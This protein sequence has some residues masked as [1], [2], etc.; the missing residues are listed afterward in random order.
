MARSPSRREDRR[1]RDHYPD[2][3]HG[4]DRWDDRDRHRRDRSRNRYDSHR[5][6]RSRRHW[7]R[8]RERD[9]DR[10]WVRE[11]DGRD[12]DGDRE[13]KRPREA[14]PVRDR[15][16]HRSRDDHR[17]KRVREDSPR[18]RQRNDSRRLAN[19]EEQER[20]AEEE[21][22]A[23]LARVAAWKKQMEEKKAKSGTSPALPLT[24]GNDSPAPSS[25]KEPQSPAPVLAKFD[26]KA[27]AKRAPSAA[28]KNRTL[29][30][31]VFI[32]TQNRS[33]KA[34]TVGIEAN[35][36]KLAPI[37]SVTESKASFG[38]GK[39]S[40]PKQAAVPVTKATAKLEED[41]VVRRKLEKLPALP[42]VNT[43]AVDSE[44]NEDEEIVGE[45]LRTDEEEAEAA[46]ES[47]LRRAQEAQQDEPNVQ[48][49]DA[50]EALDEDD[51]LD[52]FMNSLAVP[53]DG[54][55][56]STGKA[57]QVYNSDDE[58]NMDAVGTNTDEIMALTTKKK[59]KEIPV[60]DHSKIDYEPFHKAFYTEPAELAEMSQEDLDIL[61]SDLDNITLRGKNA[62]KPILKWSQGGF[63]AQLL[64]VLRDNK[65]EKPTPIQSQTLPAIMS[66]RDVMGIAKTGSGKTVAYLLPMFRHIKDQRPLEKLDGPIGLILAPTRELATQIHRECKPYLKALN[67][68]AV[69]AYGGAPIKDQIAELKRGA[70]IVVCTPGRMI[71]LLAAN[72]GRVTNLKR[73]TYAVLDEADRMFDMGFEPQITRILNNV[74]PDRQLVLFSA[75]FPDKMEWLVKRVLKNP[76]AVTVGG[77][78]TVPA[79]ITQIIELCEDKDKLTRV[80]KY[81]GDLHGVDEDA[82]SLI[83]VER[84][85][86]ADKMFVNLSAKGYPSVPIHGGREQIDRDQAISDFKAGIFP[87]MVATSV[88]ARGLDVKQLKLVINY[89]SPNHYEDYVHRVG[90]TG[91]AGN[92]GTAVTFVTPDQDRFADFL[93]NAFT[94]SKQQ[95]PEELQK[96]KESYEERK[97]SGGYKK[98]SS[99]F[100]GKGIEKLDAARELERA[101]ERKQYRNGD[102]PDEEDETEDINQSKVDELVARATGKHVPEESASTGGILPTDLA[103]HLSNAMKV[104]KVSLPGKGS[105]PRDA[106]A[107]VSA[108]AANIN[109][110]LG[111]RGTTRQGAPIDNRGPDAGAYHATLEINDFPQKAR[112]A[113]TNR[114][115]VAK[116]LESTGTSITTKGNYY[117]PGKE[118]QPGEQPKLY[119]LVE[120]DTEV[121]VTSAMSELTRLLRE[122][123]LAALEGGALSQQG[124]LGR[125][126][127]I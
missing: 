1:P 61:L 95:V 48:M 14:S 64:D 21:R 32:P 26:P 59:K 92:T 77:K 60:V 10:D 55:V 50:P 12:R 45:E 40:G 15:H 25:A 110:R 16:G 118:P 28:D 124:T 127:V 54:V 46:R 122:G 49:T 82:R 30:G 65:F 111:S 17:D 38:L 94:T 93:I 101:R 106:L 33:A 2:R 78:S 88:A 126:S 3:S 42:E 80:L 39:I 96:L 35:A 99:G 37:G 116:I 85:E 58:D 75:T 66:G 7:D 23:K 120:G 27:I 34:T 13:R 63:G 44:M 73:V 83:F 121:V 97:K 57:R 107:R 6:D 36:P 89:D 113:V 43:S 91:R 103:S 51:P 62:P 47:A 117:A 11:R 104:Q 90:R 41:E 4:R 69:C 125:Y 9:R 76:L 114:T 84:Q 74:R 87:V 31:D 71:D 8:D 112:W 22:K 68:R 56:R 98:T 29:G 70:E 119:I 53:D 20:K 5:E 102:E 109:N 108:A 24:T 86:T 67:L 115:N 81:L 100:G 105:N 18:A 19:R 72:S 79:E 52:A 123:T